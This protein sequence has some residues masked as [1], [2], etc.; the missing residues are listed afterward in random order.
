MFWNALDWNPMT[1]VVT[2]SEI[3]DDDVTALGLRC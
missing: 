2:V 1:G 3:Q